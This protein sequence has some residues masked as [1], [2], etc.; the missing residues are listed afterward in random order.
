[1]QAV[2]EHA[3]ARGDE[4]VWAEVQVGAGAGTG[5]GLSATRRG[6]DALGCRRS[7]GGISMVWAELDR[8]PL[9]TVVDSCK[10]LM[11]GGPAAGDGLD[12]VLRQGGVRASRGQVE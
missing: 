4:L 12:R 1:M 2:H 6:S 5:P 10:Q 9:R 8:A 7:I 3:R 11:P